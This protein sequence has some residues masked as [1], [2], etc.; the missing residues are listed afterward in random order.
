[1]PPE[2]T[3]HASLILTLLAVGGVGGLLSGMLGVGGGVIFVPALYFT[4]VSFV[5]EAGISSQQ[6]VGSDT[7]L[8]ET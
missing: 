3:S 7:A 2:I 1:M 6:F 4:L 8:S 5:P